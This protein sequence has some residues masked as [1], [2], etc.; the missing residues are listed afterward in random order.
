ME[1]EF[2]DAIRKS[3]P[4][5]TGKSRQSFEIREEAQGSFSLSGSPYA[6][7]VRNGLLA[8]LLRENIHLLLDGRAETLINQN[9]NLDR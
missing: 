3:W 4:V 2:L 5:D 6:V 8:D 7:Y 9:P 1:Q